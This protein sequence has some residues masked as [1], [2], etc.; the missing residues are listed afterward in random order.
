MQ[1]IVV[2]DYAALSEVAADEIASLIEANP[3]AG[4]V[5]ATGSTPIG[6]YRE[7]APRVQRGELDSSRLRVFQLDE[8]W[9]IEESDPRSLYAWLAREFIVPLRIPMENVGRLRGDARDAASECAAYE[10]KVL[11]AGCFDLAV[12]GL[13]PNGHLGFNE[14]PSDSGSPTRLVSLT[15]AS[16]ESNAHYWDRRETVPRRALTAGMDLLLASRKIILLVSGAHKR[17]IL[18]QTINLAV[19]PE[20]PASYLQNARDITVVADRAAWEDPR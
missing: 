13:G 12:L 4:L 9:G 17:D 11:A 3:N 1:L 5:L 20:L 18:S 2:Q 15:N 7:L 14:P 19:T 8:Y 10:Q 6:A 16:I